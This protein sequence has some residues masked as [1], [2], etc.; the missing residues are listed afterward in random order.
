VCCMCDA[1]HW[2][3]NETCGLGG[4]SSSNSRSGGA[5]G[6]GARVRWGGGAVGGGAEVDTATDGH[7]YNILPHQETVVPRTAQV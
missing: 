7:Q 6:Q 3:G 4:S 1:T 5:G 2:T